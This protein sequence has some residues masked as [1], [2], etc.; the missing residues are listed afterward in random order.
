MFS[1]L[2]EV[3]K[4]FEELTSL[5]G[6][7]SVAGDPK[8]YAQVAKE[9]AG[10]AQTVEVWR[11][12]RGL[13][14]ELESAKEL[15]TDSDQEM[16][17]MAKEEI[18]TLEPQLPPLEEQLKILLLPKDPN[19]EKNVLL[20]IRAGTGGDEASLFAANLFRMYTR[21]AESK[22]WKIEPV[23]SSPTE[24]GGF[25]E[26]I[27]MVSGDRPYATLKFESGVHRVQRVPETESQGRIHTSACTVA[28]MPEAEEVDINIQENE[29]KIDV[30][31][32]SGPGGQSV[33]TTDSAVRITHL[34]SGLVVICQD[35][36]SQHKNRAK[37]LKV[38][39]SRLLEAETAKANAETSEARRKMVGSGD[40]SERI[41][42]YNYPQNRITDHRIGLTLYKLDEVV[43][44]TGLGEVIDACTAYF[45]AEL[46]K[47]DASD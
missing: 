6:D 13:T 44:G 35:E 20:E 39:A 18:A 8:R 2:D 32:S 12:Y 34:P 31:R 21:Y 47:G 33:N 7:P 1:Q 25:K 3:E 43:A 9:Q 22:R 16:R 29:L 40:R 24:V 36:K 17:E 23:S 41:R 28:V 10:L 30:Y 19:D 27:C 11:R 5:M 26:V 46:L 14:E 15:L 37:A 4:R 42:T 45:N 38:L